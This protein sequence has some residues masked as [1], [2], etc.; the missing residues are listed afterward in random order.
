MA[1][2]ILIKQIENSAL[3]MRKNIVKMTYKMGPTGAHI[4]GGLS[5]VEIMSTLYLGVLKYDVNDMN[6]ELRDRVILSKGHGTMAL[7][8]AMKESGI[9]S[10]DMLMTYKD[11]ESELSAHPSMNN[12]LGIEF[13]SGSLG[14]GLS[15]GVGVCLGLKRKHNES[16]RVFVVLGDGECDEGS[17]WEAA[18]SA[19][20]FCCNNLVAIIDNNKLQYDGPTEKIMSFGSLKKKWENFGWKTVEVDGHSVSEL[21]DSLTMETNIPIAI[22]ANTIKGKGVSFMENNPEWHNHSINKDQYIRAMKELGEEVNI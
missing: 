7:Y 22:I 15:L 9:I 1:N 20:H 11:N 8:S 6:N 16:S 17:V 14:Q 18:Q 4:G 21:I 19:T 3:M 5:L 13:S 12:E 2:D 10:Q